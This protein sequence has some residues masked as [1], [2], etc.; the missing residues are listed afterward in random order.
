MDYFE[1]LFNK[2]KGSLKF[3]KTEKQINHF[4]DLIQ[5]NYM[6][7]SYLLKIENMEKWFLKNNRNRIENTTLRMSL[8]EFV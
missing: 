2:N 6:N 7:P 8:L 1:W 5:K 4:V 3:I